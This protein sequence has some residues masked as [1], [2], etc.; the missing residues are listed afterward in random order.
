MSTAAER[1]ASIRGAIAAIEA[2]AQE[3]TFAD[4]RKVRYPDL[5]VL[6]AQERRAQ[7]EAD[8]EAAGTGRISIGRGAGW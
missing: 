2:G 7:A 4:G 3:V 5:D 8:R 6:Y 1:L